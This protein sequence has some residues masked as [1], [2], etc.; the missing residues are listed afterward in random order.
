VCADGP[1]EFV[2]VQHLEGRKH[3]NKTGGGV[4]RRKYIGADSVASY[5]DQVFDLG[6]QGPS[7]P[8]LRFDVPAQPQLALCS[9]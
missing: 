8:G 2:H 6:P 1:R 7:A 4:P 3:Q 5:A 9:D